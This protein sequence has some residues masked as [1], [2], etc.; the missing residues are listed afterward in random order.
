MQA[1]RNPLNLSASS[2]EGY[3]TMH[4]Y[5]LQ[6]PLANH[7]SILNS[8]D[9]NSSGSVCA[10]KERNGASE[11]MDPYYFP[12]SMLPVSLRGP[13]V[14][15]D[16]EE[17]E[18]D[19]DKVLETGDIGDGEGEGAAFD[20][21]F[22]QQGSGASAG[23]AARRSQL[24]P[25]AGAAEVGYGAAAAIVEDGRVPVV[26][27]ESLGDLGDIIGYGGDRGSFVC[28][29]AFPAH[30]EVFQSRAPSA[31]SPWSLSN[32]PHRDREAYKRYPTHISADELSFV[33]T[34]YR[35]A[36]NS[37][38][39]QSAHSP[40]LT[41]EEAQYAAL[42]LVLPDAVV[43]Q[44]S[45]TVG[46]LMPL[47]NCSLKEFLQSF[48]LNSHSGSKSIGDSAMSSTYLEDTFS[49]EDGPRGAFNSAV[50]YR[51]IDSVEVICCIAF[52]V[53]EAIAYLNHRLPHGDA[54]SGY[55]HNDLHLDN[56]LVSYDGDVA[57]C[58]FEL[59]S[60]TPYP[61]HNPEIRRLPPATRQ[62]PHGLF[63]ETA[64]TWAFGLMLVGLLTGVDPLFTTSIVNDFSDG[65]LLSRWDRS[66]CVLDW[67]NNIKAHVEGLLLLQDP[68]GRR[69]SEA[70]SILSIC[71]KC[72]V[73][74]RGAEPLRAIDLLEEPM[75]QVYRRDFRLATRT[76]KTWTADKH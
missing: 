4:G 66:E 69:L 56:V 38:H 58:D 10:L 18:E 64:D 45:M 12:N 30:L 32:P 1:N 53:L 73:N 54:F 37:A 5:W 2:A 40:F 3:L 49:S 6:A 52:Q 59:V 17:D 57:L 7:D 62:S 28:R 44:N 9:T 8:D 60:S 24:A 25:A 11:T 31:T 15:D 70:E 67:E 13:L 29:V 26:E 68:T 27:E 23:T 76:I 47:Y 74:R 55:T 22:H 16:D 19:E 41:V 20:Y 51:P 71:S 61:T 46:L 33:F 48:L 34:A 43:T 65:P 75:F 50:K 63:S 39:C 42:H 21:Y 35:C 72:L 14:E 36:A